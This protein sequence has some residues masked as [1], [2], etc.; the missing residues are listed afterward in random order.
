MGH[1]DGGAI[2]SADGTTTEIANSTFSEN[3][4]ASLG[5]ALFLRRT[6]ATIT[7]STFEDNQAP[8]G[9]AIFSRGAL[10]IT[11]STITINPSPS[12]ESSTLFLINGTLDLVHVTLFAST[13]YTMALFNTP[14]TIDNSLLLR[15][16][17]DHCLAV[18]ST[19]TTSGSFADDTSCPGT[20]PIVAGTDI[21]TTLTSNGGPTFT[22]ALLAGSVAINAGGA[23]G[24]AT[25]QRGF[26][27]DANCDAG[28]FEFGAPSP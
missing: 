22:H 26:A 4:A 25:D 19:V 21:S 5:G 10:S 23:C 3:E 17:S 2:Y 27:R 7:G 1:G 18:T 8:G 20:S 12:P 14:T 11:N 24:L 16:S 15:S 6:D 28:A 13:T 9:S